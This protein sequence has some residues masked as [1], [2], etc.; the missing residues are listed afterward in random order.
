LGSACV[1][2]VDAS[3]AR[4]DGVLAIADFS[5]ALKSG[6]NGEIIARFALL[7]PKVDRLL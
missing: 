3:P 5:Y 6:I 1:S 4:T 2:R 7:D